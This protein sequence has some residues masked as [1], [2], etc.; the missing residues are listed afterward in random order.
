M[1]FD[2]DA[3]SIRHLLRPVR[4]RRRPST[5]GA[6]FGPTTLAAAVDAF[7]AIE[8]AG[9]GLFGLAI[10]LDDTADEQERFLAFLGREPR[11]S[12]TL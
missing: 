3:S 12:G 8:I 7:Y 5:Y 9:P 1:V 2:F 6:F 10:E 11:R 4:S